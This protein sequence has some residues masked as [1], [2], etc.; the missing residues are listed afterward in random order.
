MYNDAYFDKTAPSYSTSKDM[1]SCQLDKIALEL[2]STP[3]LRTVT[4]IFEEFITDITN[5]PPTEL[6]TQERD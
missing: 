3:K 1:V 5:N 2:H 4:E 6:V